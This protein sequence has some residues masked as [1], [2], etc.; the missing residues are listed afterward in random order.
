MLVVQ[1]FALMFL[2]FLT[3]EVV[4]MYIPTFKVEQ[5]IQHRYYAFSVNLKD[6]YLHI[7]ITE[8]HHQFLQVVW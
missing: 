5:L 7:P 2:W 6:T 4:L 1:G 3:V 8:H